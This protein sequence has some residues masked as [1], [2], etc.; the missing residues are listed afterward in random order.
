MITNSDFLIY[1][2]FSKLLKKTDKKFKILGNQQD[3]MFRQ[4]F[5]FHYII[6]QTK[7]Y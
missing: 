2:E 1:V 7:D 6:T 3:K 4:N 5:N